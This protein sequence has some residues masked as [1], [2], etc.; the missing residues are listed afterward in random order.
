MLVLSKNLCLSLPW[1]SMGRLFGRIE[2]TDA[3]QDLF[4]LSSSLAILIDVKDSLHIN[5]AK[6]PPASSESFLCWT[7]L[8]NT[9]FK[10]NVIMFRAASSSGYPE[11]LSCTSFAKSQIF[12]HITAATGT[13]FYS[14]PTKTHRPGSVLFME[15]VPPNERFERAVGCIKLKM[16]KWT[17][18]DE[19]FQRR[20]SKIQVKRIVWH[21][22]LQY[23]RFCL[24]FCSRRAPLLTLPSI[25]IKPR[26]TI[27]Q[28][29]SLVWRAFLCESHFLPSS[30]SCDNCRK[31]FPNEID[32]QEPPL[33]RL[34]E[35][36]AM[37]KN[38]SIH[39]DAYNISDTTTSCI[40]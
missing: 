30:A 16:E 11:K 6:S 31:S 32:Q 18:D 5:A 3:G 12:L 17:S 29:D 2:C 27:L 28:K 38:W 15:P 35:V 14:C 37:Y 8:E 10:Q 23:V 36:T 7:I 22:S 39:D 4:H 20:K 26:W 9:G 13:H 25:W 24:L 34:N 19:I 40:D 21:Y 1:I 33:T